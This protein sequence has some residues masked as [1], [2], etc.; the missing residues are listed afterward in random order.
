MAI[1]EAIAGLASTGLNFLGASKDRKMQ[2]KFAKKGLRWRVN[3]GLAAGIHPLAAIGFNGPSFNPVHQNLGAGLENVGQNIDRAIAAKADAPA[4]AVAA[5]A[6]QLALENAGL[7]N[8]MLEAQIAD[9]HRSWLRPQAGQPPAAP[10]G[11]VAQLIA[12][13]ADTGVVTEPTMYEEFEKLYGEPADL[14]GAMEMARQATTERNWPVVK[15]YAGKLDRQLLEL[16]KRELRGNFVKP[17][18]RQKG[19]RPGSA[20]DRILRALGY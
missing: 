17:G 2:E 11:R 8:K 1:F 18:W 7:Q 5:R 14:Y 13:Q 4:R 3:D 19:I 20:A 6:S 12:G 16:V 10:G 15:S 9:I